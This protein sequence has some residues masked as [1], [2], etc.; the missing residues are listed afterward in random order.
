VHD[1]AAL[2]PYLD[3]AS[4][5]FFAMREKALAAL[6]E[7]TRARRLVQGAYGDY[8]LLRVAQP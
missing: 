5:N 4:S 6:P 2:A 7:A 8:R 3:A 1:L